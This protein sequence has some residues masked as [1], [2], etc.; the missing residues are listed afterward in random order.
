[1]MPG[2]MVLGAKRGSFSLNLHKIEAQFTADMWVSRTWNRWMGTTEID[3]KTGEIMP[4]APRNKTERALMK[5]SFQETADKMGLT[6]SSLQAVLWYYEQSLYGA[7]GTPK[8]SWSF[9]DA[10]KKVR[11]DQK[12]GSAQTK[13]L[14]TSKK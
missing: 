6:T 2:A 9:S 11:D 3:P 14:T 10:A 4:D 5:Q 12:A 1:M 8:E 13:T 7:H